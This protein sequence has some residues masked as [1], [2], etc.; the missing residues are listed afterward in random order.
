[1]AITLL[2]IVACFAAG[3]VVTYQELSRFERVFLSKPE[4]NIVKSYEM[5]SFRVILRHTV[6]ADGTYGV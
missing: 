2:I 4:M 6:L 5:K 1:M 3:M